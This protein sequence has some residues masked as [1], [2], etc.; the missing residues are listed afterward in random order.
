MRRVIIVALGLMMGAGAA[1][2]QL[3][4][5]VGPVNNFAPIGPGPVIG[6]A[7]PP[8]VCTNALDYSVACNSQY[9]G[10]TGL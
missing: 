5:S 1:L 2:A 3:T 8:A 10:V 7:F 6:N 9:L 4:P